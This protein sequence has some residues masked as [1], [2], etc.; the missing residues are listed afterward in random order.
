MLAGL[1]PVRDLWFHSLAPFGFTEGRE[2]REV[3]EGLSRE[4][5]PPVGL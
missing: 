3:V 1:S 4:A 2:L 5:C